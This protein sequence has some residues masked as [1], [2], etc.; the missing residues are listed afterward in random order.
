M[1][2]GLPF[3][4]SMSM[5]APD[6][7]YTFAV[8]A[9]DA[10]GNLSAASAPVT[11]RTTPA[12]TGTLSVQH[13]G[14]GSA[15]ANQIGTTLQLANRGTTATGLSTVT[16]RYWFTGDAPSPGYQ[17]WCDWARIGCAN[18]KVQV[19]KLGTA[20]AGAD[21]YLEVGFTS[22]SLAPGASAGDVQLRVA[23][24]DWPA[25]DQADDHSYRVSDALADFDRVTA[26]S[27]GALA[28]GLEPR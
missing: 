5:L 26:H 7:T 20:R 22:G 10:A 28:W 13:K 18:V 11:V 19:V 17:V 12:T 14:T 4:F 9:K 21:A 16:L 25:F 15:T 3:A 2:F 27:G 24:S 1:K 8:R 23:K 6:T